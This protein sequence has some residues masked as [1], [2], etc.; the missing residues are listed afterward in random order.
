MKIGE[1]AEITGITKR[2][3]D[4][5]TNLGLLKAERSASNYRYYSE[6][7]VERLKKIEEM[8]AKG[9]SLQEIKK[10][11]EVENRYEEI[12]IQE[13][14]LRMQS[15]Q[16]EVTTLLEQVKEQPAKES[17]KNKLSSES[18]ALMQA[19]LLLLN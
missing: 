3:I 15:L 1:L 11:F 9:M 5:Y 8:K 2:T 7:A 17:I 13:L 14:R 4:Y 12:D 10:T 18:I 16:N 19:L 6:D